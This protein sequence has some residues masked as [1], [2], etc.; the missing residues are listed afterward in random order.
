MLQTTKR[1]LD[2]LSTGT[3]V[4]QP[5]IEISTVNLNVVVKKSSLD[6]FENSTIMDKETK[7]SFEMPMLVDLGIFLEPNTTSYESVDQQ[8]SKGNQTT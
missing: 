3:A 7:A 8:V 5:P 1:I 4:D 2:K 6:S